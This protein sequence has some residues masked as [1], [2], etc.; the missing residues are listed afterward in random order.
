MKIIFFILMIGLFENVFSKT[1]FE[2]LLHKIESGEKKVLQELNG[3]SKNQEILEKELQHILNEKT[4]QEDNLKET[5]RQIDGLVQAQKIYEESLQKG[6]R[7]LYLSEVEP[8][9]FEDEV[10]D[11]KRK[12]MSLWV[13]SE[14]RNFQKALSVM[15]ELKKVKNLNAQLAQSLLQ[16][17]QSLQLKQEEALAVRGEKNNLLGLLKSQKQFYE[18]SIKEKIDAQTQMQNMMGDLPSAVV[19]DRFLK[20]K[21]RLL[22]PTQGRLQ[23]IFGPYWD[24]RLKVKLYNK[25]I[26]LAAP[27]GQKVVAVFDGKVV[28]QDWF[29]GYGKVLI[30]DHGQGFFSL[31]AHLN[32]F[33]KNVGDWVVVG[34]TIAKV[35]DTD[36]LKGPSLYFE[37]R[38]KG[39]S[40]D[41][42]PWFK[43]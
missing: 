12:W 43:R 33:L 35:G 11:E 17:Q 41:P 32:E 40:E 1:R 5:Q 27:K 36:S 6:F 21:G 9:G 39:I 37:V 30:L 34:E 13:N 23:K 26:D 29:V 15:D 8:R 14:K 19:S 25:G 24:E 38:R 18:K 22:W 7:A 28:F 31:Y 10:H 42:L 3:L 2:E 16:Q 4:L 20:N